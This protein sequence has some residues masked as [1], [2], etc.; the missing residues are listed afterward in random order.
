MTLTV[1]A[2][3]ATAFAPF[4]AFIEPP[5]GVGERKTLSEWLKPIPGRSQQGHLNRVASSTLPLVLTQVECHPG[6]AQLFLP[7]DVSRYLVTVMPPDETGAPDPDGAVAFL[8][9]GTLGV[10]YHPGTWH[11]GISV[12]DSDASFAVLM[13][14]G[15]DDDDRFATVSPLRVVADG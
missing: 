13:C 6:A 12:L 3:D 11:A 10:A 8:V 5:A 9:P 7:V 4:G 14:R 2:P 1:R 15:G